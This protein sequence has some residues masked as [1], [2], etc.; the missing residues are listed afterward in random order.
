MASLLIIAKSSTFR[1][2]VIHGRLLHLVLGLVIAAGKPGVNLGTEETE[3]LAIFV[4]RYAPERDPVVDGF[5]SGFVGMVG[6]QAF[7]VHPFVRAVALRVVEVLEKADK[8]VNLLFERC[9]D[10]G[11]LLESN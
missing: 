8:Q 5:A 10:L 9:E 2:D 3:P 4:V 6:H 7:N 1:V 11:H